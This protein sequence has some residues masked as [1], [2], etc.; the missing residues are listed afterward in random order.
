MGIALTEIGKNLGGLDAQ[1]AGDPTGRL[2][3]QVE[4]S[5]AGR[6]RLLRGRDVHPDNARYSAHPVKALIGG[7]GL[8][9]PSRSRSARIVPENAKFMARNSR[10]K[11]AACSSK[12]FAR[13]ACCALL[14]IRCRHDLSQYAR[15]AGEL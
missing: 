12:R 14:G 13:M 9:R 1:A 3:F 10:F 7:P 4:S 5:R 15:D 2:E 11:A 6:D 8:N